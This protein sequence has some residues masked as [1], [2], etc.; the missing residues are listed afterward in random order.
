MSQLNFQ[1][2]ADSLSQKRLASSFRTP[3]LDSAGHVLSHF[4]GHTPQC[5]LSSRVSPA[6]VLV[7]AGH[8]YTV[9]RG[10]H[11]A[12]T[13]LLTCHVTQ[14]FVTAVANT[15]TVWNNNTQRARTLPAQPKCRDM[16]TRVATERFSEQAHV[17]DCHDKTA[18]Y[19]RKSFYVM[20][21]CHLNTSPKFLT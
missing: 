21:S 14:A 10:C 9:A 5:H 11:L 20:Q 8:H 19:F 15:C 16:R 3:Q 2:L 1:P 7:T 12:F 4:S 13:T 6:T 17:T 18:P